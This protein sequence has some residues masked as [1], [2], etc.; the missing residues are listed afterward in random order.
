ML[1]QVPLTSRHYGEAQLTSVVMLLDGRPCADI[2]EEDLR[3]AAHRVNRLTETEPR[4]LQIRA[5]VLG[6]ALDWLESGVAAPADDPIFGYPFGQ[7]GLREGIEE[8][9]RELAR[10]SPRRRHRYTLVDVANAI[11][12]PSWL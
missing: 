6:I 11:R 4:A 9:L 2:T 7:R 5:L 10:H 3:D 8:A 12:P 1:D